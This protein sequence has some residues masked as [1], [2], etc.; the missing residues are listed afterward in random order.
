MGALAQDFVAE[1]A[2]VLADLERRAQRHET[3]CGTGSL[4][5]RA[6]GE[7]PPVVLFHGAS[8]GWSQ[9]VRNID[10]LAMT[11]TVWTVDLPGFGDSA[12]PMVQDH[13]GL[14][15][16]LAEGLE[17]LLGAELPAPIAGF[18]FG[19]VVAAHLAAFHPRLV[20]QLIIVDSG[21][22]DTPRHPV[23]LQRLRGLDGEAKRAAARANLLAIMLHDPQSVDELALHVA[24]LN[25]PRA[26]LSVEPLVLPDKLLVALERV[27]CPVAAIW[28]DCDQLH[29]NPPV[30]EK[31][32]RRVQPDAEFRVVPNA[33][34]WSMYEKPAAF[35]KHLLELLAQ[36]RARASGA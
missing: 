11:H 7:G 27:T 28:G 32:L 21:G 36:D 17:R 19:G 20:R 13:A 15:A 10:T 33:G 1:P 22:L 30:Q 4:V 31:A 14:A 16:A 9:W 35:N 34:H 12:L 23:R 18:S 3:R 29:S 25:A 6:W 24:A 26:R 8:G 5:W 2:A